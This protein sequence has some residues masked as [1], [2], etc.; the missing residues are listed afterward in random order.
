[1]SLANAEIPL[2]GVLEH[3]EVKARTKIGAAKQGGAKSPKTIS[4]DFLFEKEGFKEIPMIL[5]E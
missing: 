1:M 4:V 2:R 3:G 5:K